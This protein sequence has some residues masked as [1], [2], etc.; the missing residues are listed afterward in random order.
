[1]GFPGPVFR[2][3]LLPSQVLNYLASEEGVINYR[4]GFHILLLNQETLRFWS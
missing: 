2:N 3:L 4:R 1:V